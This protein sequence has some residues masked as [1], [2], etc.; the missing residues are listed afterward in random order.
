MPSLVEIGPID[1]GDLKI[2]RSL[3]QHLG[4]RF[5]Q[6]KKF[7]VIHSVLHVI[8][9]Y[10]SFSYPKKRCDILHD[11]NFSSPLPVLFQFSLYPTDFGKDFK[12][13]SIYFYFLTLLFLLWKGVWSE[14]L[15]EQFESLLHQNAMLKHFAIFSFDV[16]FCTSLK[17]RIVLC[18]VWMKW[19]KWSEEVKN[20]KSYGP[21][22]GK[23]HEVG[24]VLKKNS[25]INYWVHFR[26]DKRHIHYICLS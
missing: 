25:L 20:V 19:T 7:K 5:F 13:S 24:H 3:H 8:I 14:S 21:S 11:Q 2:I 9:R 15:F 1:S 10:S 12:K 26:I 6:K 23:V 16:S 4:S 22:T 18:Q 17:T